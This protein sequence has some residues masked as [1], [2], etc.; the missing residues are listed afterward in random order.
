MVDNG[1][2]CSQV[3][4]LLDV[5]GEW[6]DLVELSEGTA[7]VTANLQ[8]K[9]NIYRTHH[10]PV[11]FG[12]IITRLA[13]AQ[14]RLD[15][16]R[17]WLRDLDVTVLMVPHVVPTLTSLER[18]LMI[19]QLACDYTVLSDFAGDASTDAV[20]TPAR[21]ARLVHDEMS[22]GATGVLIG[23]PMPLDLSG[24]I[25]DLHR[26]W[27]EGLI[28]CAGVDDLIFGAPDKAL[29]VWLLEYVGREVNLGSIR[30]DD[31]ISLETLRLGLRSDTM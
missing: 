11:V 7:L 13:M 6:I 12:S 23:Y 31:V 14:G 8:T 25:C 17:G 30:T 20:F 27:L 10:V 2:A 5:A 18:L 9:L 22:A 26:H 4:N 3:A 15:R 29:Q 24:S 16:L 19:E 21:S 1:L 28:G